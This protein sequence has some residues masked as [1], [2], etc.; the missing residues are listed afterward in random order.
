MANLVNWVG[1]A[2]FGTEEGGEAAPAAG[3]APAA[4]GGGGHG[5]AHDGEPCHGHGGQESHGHGHGAE[6]HGQEEESPILSKAEFRAIMN[7]FSADV[8]TPEIAARLKAAVDDG[9]S[10]DD[11]ATKVQCEI[12]AELGHDPVVVQEMFSRVLAHY[13][14]DKEFINEFVDFM[15]DESNACDLAQLGEEGLKKKHAEAEAAQQQEMQQEMMSLQKEQMKIRSLHMIMKMSGEEQSKMIKESMAQ[16]RQILIQKPEMKEKVKASLLQRGIPVEHVNDPIEL[17][18]IA[19][20]KMQGIQDETKAELAKDAEDAGLSPDE[21]L[22]QQMKALNVRA[23]L[24]QETYGGGGGGGGGHG[25]SHNGEPCQGHGHGGQE[26]HGHGHGGEHQPAVG[27]GA[28]RFDTGSKVKCN[29][30]ASNGW[31]SGTVVAKNYS[32]PHWPPGQQ[33]AYQVQLDSGQLIFAP[34]DRSDIIESA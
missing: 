31:H 22:A 7:K 29:M 4:E 20:E 24:F 30:G 11:E 26:S 13:E 19:E 27:G 32:E 33:A 18:A 15:E 34:Y 9:R 12:I 28:L 3:A 2:L 10:V 17:V 14:E 8:A 5:H 23:Q 25:H 21:Y 1:E 6:P 16:M